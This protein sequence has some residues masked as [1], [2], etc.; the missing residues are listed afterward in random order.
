MIDSLDVRHLWLLVAIAV[1]VLWV[2]HHFS[3][4]LVR[5]VITRSRG[6]PAR[7]FW[8]RLFDPKADSEILGVFQKLGLRTGEATPTFLCLYW[9]HHPHRRARPIGIRLR[10]PLATSRAW[11]R[12]DV[13]AELRAATGL[14]RLRVYGESV[15][16]RGPLDRCP[17]LHTLGIPDSLRERWRTRTPD[18]LIL[19]WS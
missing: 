8:L 17:R 4:P 6:V 2:M 5:R 3:K 14:H 16:S 19:V 1:L 10:P 11:Q 15:P 12:D 18:E 9:D 13:L 7:Q